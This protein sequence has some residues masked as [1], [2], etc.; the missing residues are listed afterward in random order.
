MAVRPSTKRVDSKINMMNNYFYINAPSQRFGNQ[1]ILNTQ[2]SERTFNGTKTKKGSQISTNTL[3]IDRSTGPYEDGN[4]ATVNEVVTKDTFNQDLIL[5]NASTKQ[6]STISLY[7]ES[8]NSKF[9]EV[10]KESEHILVSNTNDKSGFKRINSL[11]HDKSATE[12]PVSDEL[13]LNSP[14]SNALN[15]SIRY[16]P[17]SKSSGTNKTNTNFSTSNLHS[18]AAFIN[19]ANNYKTSNN[20]NILAKSMINMSSSDNN[21]TDNLSVGNINNKRTNDTVP[22]PHVN[23]KGFNSG[24]V[25]KMSHVIN[26]TTTTNN[27]Q[28]ISQKYSVHTNLTA[29]SQNSVQ[30]TTIRTNTINNNSLY[31]PISSLQQKKTQSDLKVDSVR[32]VS[33]NFSVSDSINTKEKFNA[34]KSNAI[35][36]SINP[37]IHPETNIATNVSSSTLR[38]SQSTKTSDKFGKKHILIEKSKYLMIHLR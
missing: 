34:T 9:K 27:N 5:K 11:T 23:N 21:I 16:N 32:I 26:T 36:S 8:N 31:N 14:S 35:T 10:S 38:N 25:S 13:N 20:I 18:S 30:S 29:N 3:E 28:S 37:H 24:T 2:E 19:S 1:H 22:S 15:H 6:L 33:N 12:N 17:L 4:N 7:D